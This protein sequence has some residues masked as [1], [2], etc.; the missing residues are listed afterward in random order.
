M[1]LPVLP[2]SPPAEKD[3]VETVTIV[4][5]SRPKS[6]VLGW[7]K[8]FFRVI[9][10]SWR[11]AALGAVGATLLYF[12]ILL[13]TQHLGWNFWLLDLGLALFVPMLI[14]GLC[15]ALTDLVFLLLQLA[16]R[17]LGWALTKVGLHRRWVTLPYRWLKA[18]PVW[19]V[20]VAGGILLLFGIYYFVLGHTG[21]DFT[22]LWMFTTLELFTGGVIGLILSPAFKLKKPVLVGLLGVVAALNLAA[23]L[24]LFTPGTD[25]YLVPEVTPL[26]AVPQLAI[27]NPGE[28]GAYQ[29][30]TLFYGSGTDQHR[31]EYGAGVQLKTATVDASKILPDWSGFGG[32]ILSWLWGFDAGSLPVNG[33]IWYPVGEGPFPL[34]L[35][36]HGNHAMQSFSDP[37]YAYLGELLAS[38]GFIAV[39]VDENF[40]NGSVFGDFNNKET[41]VRAWLL[42]HHL[43]AWQNWNETAGNIFYQ[44]VDFKNIALIGHSRGGE[45]VALAASFSKWGYSLDIPAAEQQALQFPIKA[46]VAIAPADTFRPYGRPQALENTDY[47]VLQ[48]AHDSDVTTFTGS[49]QYQD[50]SFSDGQY[51]FKSSVYIYRANHNQ[52]NTVWGSYEY[53]PPLAWALNQQ[54]LLTGEEQRQVA[55]VYTGAFLEAALHQEQAYLPFLRNH[56]TAQSW[57]PKDIYLTQFADSNLKMINDF[58]FANQNTTSLPGGTIE[59]ENLKTWQQK[60]MIYRDQK[61]TSQR[62]WV[63]F[64]GWERPATGTGVGALPSYSINLPDNFNQ[65]AKTGLQGRLV[66]SLGRV[67]EDINPLDLTVELVDKSGQVARQPLSHFG[68]MQPALKTQLKKADWLEGIAMG[69][70]V[71]QVLQTY[72]LPLADFIQAN[73]QFSPA[74]LKTIRFS[75]DRTASGQIILDNIGFY[76]G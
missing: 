40:L 60:P 33:R 56:Y 52:F 9:A 7:G 43:K 59:A 29:V 13:L 75:F 45:T 63:A 73:P 51:H 8:D 23:G 2:G 42:L 55:K 68:P 22:L 6:L 31:L 17:F 69:G 1:G 47:M 64:L 14:L 70:P 37:G 21:A 41:P 35:I 34:V 72:E 28:A 39:S 65:Q 25:D 46:V 36:A 3:L 26:Q 61:Q 16:F 27:A 12:T 10:A 48:G 24:W 5:P 44:K 38:R 53:P 76:A 71:E 62:N 49:R 74:E 58:E 4:S 67:G 57:L 20:R 11:G 30:Q 66:F 15:G 54:P 18:V 50:T 32:S 19:F